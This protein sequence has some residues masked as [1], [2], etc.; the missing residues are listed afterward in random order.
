[1]IYGRINFDLKSII[2][3]GISYYY[4]LAGESCSDLE[5]KK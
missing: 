1:M 5:E 2:F 4:M 3:Y